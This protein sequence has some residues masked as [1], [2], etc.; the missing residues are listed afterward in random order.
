ML[1]ANSL[2]IARDNFTGEVQ[3]QK[4]KTKLKKKKA[5]VVN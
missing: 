5:K 3:A 1:W 2:L 4:K